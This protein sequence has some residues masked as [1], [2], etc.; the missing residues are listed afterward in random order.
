M[1]L[2]D[3]KVS[4]DAV[5][6]RFPQYRALVEEI[7]EMRQLL[8]RVTN[9]L[10][11]PITKTTDVRLLETEGSVESPYIINSLFFSM[12]YKIVLPVLV[13]GLVAVGGALF[14]SGG[15]GQIAQTPSET[16]VA[17]TGDTP[18][19]DSSQAPQT[20][21]AQ[22][23]NNVPTK[24]AASASVNDLLSEFSS[25]ISNEQLAY[26]DGVSADMF[27]QSELSG[28]ESDAYDY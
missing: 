13:L 5:I 18:S 27:A 3:E 4:R 11:E 6:Q 1:R 24:V 17:Q 22:P 25:D 19:N 2:L 14:L 7:N 10:P 26:D 28:L 15:D 16:P 9:A 21:S 12:N 20:G 8:T 23:G